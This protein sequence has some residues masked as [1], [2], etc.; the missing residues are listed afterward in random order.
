MKP[1]V[2]QFYLEAERNNTVL[3]KILTAITRRRMVFTSFNACAEPER[4]LF[5]V[6][7]VIEDTEE[8]VGKFSRQLEKQ[9]DI[10]HVTFFK[11]LT[12]TI[13]KTERPQSCLTS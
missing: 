13:C 11:Q 6:K 3:V 1:S 7:F 10:L 12:E 2:S 9:I 8:N 5:Q 4:G